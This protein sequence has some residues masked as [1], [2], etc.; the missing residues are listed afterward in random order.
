MSPS[1][2]VVAVVWRHFLRRKCRRLPPE[3]TSSAVIGRQ[4]SEHARAR[5][6]MWTIWTISPGGPRRFF[7]PG[8]LP[9]SPSLVDV[10]RLQ[11]H[12]P[13]FATPCRHLVYPL[14][15]RATLSAQHATARLITPQCRSAALRDSTQCSCSSPPERG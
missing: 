8:I 13:E 9:P 12:Q 15:S 3:C 14:A 11:P 2:L 4:L 10:R 7:D 6:L 5:A 1:E